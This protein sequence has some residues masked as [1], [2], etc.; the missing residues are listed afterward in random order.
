MGSFFLNGRA[1]SIGDARFVGEAI[2]RSW[3]RGG[4]P[5]ASGRLPYLFCG[6]GSCRDCNVLA[7]GVPEVPAC[8]LPARA[9][10]SVRTGD[11][12]GEDNALS[13]IAGPALIQGAPRRCELLVVGAGPAGV[14]AAEAAG[15]AGV[16]DILI[17]EARLVSDER[18]LSVRPVLGRAGALVAFE[19]GIERRV[20][21]RCAVLATGAFDFIPNFPGST[22]PGV[23]PMDILERYV[24]RKH[25]PGSRFL[26]HGPQPRVKRLKN[27]LQ[28]LGALQ[29]E[30]IGEG[31]ILVS[32]GDENGLLSARI[33]PGG[34]KLR[35]SPRGEKKILADTVVVAGRR[36][37]S[38]GLARVLGC[39]V[40]FDPALRGDC[41]SLG[42][43]G[44]SSVAGVFLAGEAANPCSEEQARESGWRAGAAAARRVISTFP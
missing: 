10:I 28:A 42:T 29:V 35:S 8:R 19:N 23:L 4:L 34:E 12:L 31:G 32:V 40:H 11:E 27:E 16:R 18:V 37:P 26:L 20:L 24:E 21:F 3:G 44:E 1:V 14:A 43:D 38:L 13:R 36:L 2:V 39:A 7:E 5:E 15:A 25:R 6:N 9:E 33:A 41:A 22:L 30:T 17:L